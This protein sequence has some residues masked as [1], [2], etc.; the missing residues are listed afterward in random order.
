VT[1]DGAT[2]LLYVNGV[3]VSSR[4]Q[5]GNIVTSTNPLQIGGDSLFGQYF[6]GIIDEVRVYNVALTPAQI[7]ADMSSPIGSVSLLPVASL[8]STNITFSNQTVGSSDAHRVMVTNTGSA[9]LSISSIAISGPQSNE[10]VEINNCA[11]SLAPAG[12]NCTISV[13]FTPGA[14]GTH[15]ATIT[16]TDNAPGNPHTIALSGTGAASSTLLISPRVVAL[17]PTRAQQFASNLTGV[18]W[19]VDGVVSGSTS[20]GT[21]TNAGLYSPPSSPGTHT[22]TVTTSDRSQSANATAYITTNPGVF[23]HH[24]DNLRTGQNLNET[25]LSPANVTAATFGKLFAYAVDGIAHAAPLY[26]ANVNIPGQ[27]HHNV[28]YVATEH[29]SVYGFDADGLSSSP[30]WH[31]SF[32]NPAAGITSVPAGETSEYNDIY[33]EIGITGTPV[34]D[35]GSGTLYVVA[36]TKEVV[37]GTT[38]YVQRLHA[39]D[40]TTG[41]EKFGGPVVIQASVAG[42]GDGSQAGQV[43]FNPLRENQRPALLLNNGVVNVGFASHGDTSPWHGWVLGYNST[44]LQR[45]MTYNNTANGSGAGIWQSG[46]GLASDSTGDIYF[47]TGNGTFDADIGGVDYGDSF[48]KISSNGTV[49]DYFT[50]MDQGKLN[51]QNLDLGAGGL[52]LLPDQAGPYPHLAISAGKDQNIYLL[53]RDNMGHSN[54]SS[55]QNLQT[56]VNIF[57]NGTT[58]EPGNFSFPVYFNG[59][60]YF[61]PINDVVKAFQLTDGFLST[62]PTA[63][64]SE[65]YSYPGGTM[66]ISANGTT[67]GILWAVQRNGFATGILRAYD[68]TNLSNELYN[69]NQSSRDTLDVAAKFSIPLVVNGKVFVASQSRLTVYGLLP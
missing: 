23:T 36:K 4:A 27:G 63:Q 20:S 64:S 33:P 48:E 2:L 14:T 28:V 60:V 69:T 54:P 53:N 29:D 35:P 11:S 15:S 44:S 6:N 65:V 45:V 37:G 66:A 18:I 8:S 10:F 58:A 57:P 49:A 13:T 47:V 39:L 41:A 1:Y 16:I 3:Q 19:S 26:V 32:I 25:V 5:T 43:P 22:I 40:I 61:S 9:G 55:N 51:A 68:A 7:Q 17:T 59:Y 21:I 24:N 38:N 31:V 67:N 34:I 46:G 50:P 42:T 52:L 12:D 56:L 30:L 62:A